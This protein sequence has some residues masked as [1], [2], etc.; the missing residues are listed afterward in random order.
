MTKLFKPKWYAVLILILLW[1]LFGFFLLLE[2][3]RQY[4]PRAEPVSTTINIVGLVSTL[5][6]LLLTL[7][8]LIAI[9][10]F[11]LKRGN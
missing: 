6:F 4:F 7:Y 5:G 11:F 10:L 8:F 2:S 1:I 3:G 9:I